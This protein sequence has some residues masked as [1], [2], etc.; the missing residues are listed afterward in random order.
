[1]IWKGH[2]SLNYGVA[3]VYRIEPNN[4]CFVSSCPKFCKIRQRSPM[5]NSGPWNNIPG[6]VIL[7]GLGDDFLAVTLCFSFL[8]F[9][10]V[11]L[12]VLK[13]IVKCSVEFSE[14]VH[15]EYLGWSALITVSVHTFW[16]CFGGGD[17]LGFFFF[18]KTAAPVNSHRNL[19]REGFHFPEGDNCAG[20]NVFFYFFVRRAELRS[21]MS[22]LAPPARGKS[23][24]H[25]SYL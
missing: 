8:I 19:P 22:G 2:L 10:M 3:S 16:A 15:T 1:M 11:M 7:A 14:S 23:L 25:D 5:E 12:T 20:L 6:F 13:V 24:A 21:F 4:R 9:E 18:T 17:Y